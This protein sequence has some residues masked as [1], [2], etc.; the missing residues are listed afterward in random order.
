MTRKADF[1]AVAT[2]PTI[3][4]NQTGPGMNLDVEPLA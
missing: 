3:D 2:P 1:N 4:P